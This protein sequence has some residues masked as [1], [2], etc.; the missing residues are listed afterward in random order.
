M[1]SAVSKPIIEA[2]ILISRGL[3]SPP[4]AAMWNP[5]HQKIP[6][7]LRRGGSLAIQS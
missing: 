5:D 6:R 2:N 7:C 4:L 1:D 3:N